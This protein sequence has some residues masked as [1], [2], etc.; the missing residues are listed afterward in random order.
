[1]SK[2]ELT[3]QAV[4]EEATTIAA[5]LG[6]EGLTIG[7]LATAT[8]M[9]KSGL[10]GHF[11]SKEALQLQVLA[12]AREN[13]TDLVIRPALAAPRGEP[14]LRVM[15]DRWLELGRS[16]AAGCL[17]VSAATEFDDRDGLVRDQLVHDHQD[18]LDSVAQMVRAGISEGHFRADADAEQ[19]A[20]DLN[21]MML[22]FYH[23]HRLMRD[24]RAEARTRRA[25]DTLL[26]NARP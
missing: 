15:F 1:M 2:G 17:F 26:D 11:R 8:N 18:M 19:F 16:F 22:G 6:L 12:F 7:S 20:H 24:P 4:L 23:S 3:K 21:S 25:F 14:R 5:R 9:S 10:F 13:F